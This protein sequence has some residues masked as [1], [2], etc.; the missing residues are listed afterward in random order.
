MITAQGYWCEGR[1]LGLGYMHMGI[2]KITYRFGHSCKHKQI[3]KSPKQPEL[4]KT[5]SRVRIFRKLCS[6]VFV[7]TGHQGV[8]GLSLLFDIVFWVQRLL[9]CCLLTLYPCAMFISSSSSLSVHT[10][11]SPSRCPVEVAFDLPFPLSYTQRALTLRGYNATS[12][13]WTKVVSSVFCSSFYEEILYKTAASCSCHD[14]A[15]A[16]ATTSLSSK[17]EK[18]VGAPGNPEVPLYVKKS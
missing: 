11:D 2:F 14:Y 13:V 18:C 17:D 1:R 10:S 9:V 8:F 16:V 6:T 5:T 12:K 4:W 3:F 7:Y 15:Q